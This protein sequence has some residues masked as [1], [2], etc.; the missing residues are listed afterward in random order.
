MILLVFIYAHFHSSQRNRQI[1]LQRLRCGAGRGSCSRFCGGR[2]GFLCGGSS[3]RCCRCGCCRCCRSGC[4]RSGRGGHRSFCGG[5]FFCGRG[6]FLR[7]GN[8]DRAT[9]PLHLAGF[10]GIAD[11]VAA[12]EYAEIHRER[13]PR[14]G[15]LRQLV[16]DR[17][18]PTGFLF[19]MRQIHTQQ[20]RSR[21]AAAGRRR[22]D[23]IPEIALHISQTGIV[24]DVKV[25]I[26]KTLA[27]I[28]GHFHPIV[29]RLQFLQRHFQIREFQAHGVL[30]LVG[31]GGGHG[32]IVVHSNRKCIGKTVDYSCQRCRA[33]AHSSGSV[34]A[35]GYHSGVRTAPRY[36]FL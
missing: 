1:L 21:I 20:I 36:R 33:V 32:D 35:D 30:Q 28:K 7:T 8:G 24:N 18:D 17:A 9:L 10:S 19:G 16:G 14:L 23:L 5:S 3:H 34:A 6:S 11:P 27:D 15:I 29:V 12:F 25:H 22:D 4:G 26:A 31:L 13:I 2:S